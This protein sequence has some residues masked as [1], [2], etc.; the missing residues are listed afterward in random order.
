CKPASPFVMSRLTYWFGRS[1]RRNVCARSRASS[2]VIALRGVREH[3][4]AEQSSPAPLSGAVSAAEA[5]GA[6]RLNAT[7]NMRRS[8][9]GLEEG[10]VNDIRAQN[11]GG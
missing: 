6:M 3:G 4:A 5:S 7:S 10:F 8:I 1:E 9:N 11:F 2:W